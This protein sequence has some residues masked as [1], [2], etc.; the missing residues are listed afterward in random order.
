MTSSAI[1]EWKVGDS[2]SDV[3]VSNL[4]RTQ[5]VQYA[6]ASGDFNPLHTDEVFAREVAGY[7]SVFAHGM[8]TMGMTGKLIVATFGPWALV[9]YGVRFKAQVWPGD[10]LTAH[11]TISAVR[12]E[13]SERQIDL[14]ISTV[15]QHGD[16]VLSGTAAVKPDAGASG[17]LA[18]PGEMVS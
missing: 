14:A 17:V 16:E 8:L 1:T 11:V 12:E 4:R 6:G 7:R 2:F 13:G 9:R 18:R 3:V 5:L 15:N 10:T